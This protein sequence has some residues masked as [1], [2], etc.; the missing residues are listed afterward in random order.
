[1]LVL[2]RRI[3]E[4]VVIGN[5][6]TVTVV[7]VRGDKVR[8][9]ILAP[10]DVPVHRQEVYEAIRSMRPDSPTRQVIVVEVSLQQLLHELGA[11]APE[12]IR[13]TRFTNEGGISGN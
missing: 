11:T 10:R 6:I 12:D 13:S 9:G 4:S 7:D 2:S 5:D 3:N 1:M 8:L